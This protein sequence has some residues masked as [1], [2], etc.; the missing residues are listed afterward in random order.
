MQGPSGK[1]M[2]LWPA[3]THFMSFQLILVLFL[4]ACAT[5]ALPGGA[6]PDSTGGPAPSGLLC[7]LLPSAGAPAVTS[8]QPRFSWIV[9]S[10]EPDDVQSAYEIRVATAEAAAGPAFYDSGKVVGDQSVA[11]IYAG[12]ALQARTEYWWRVRT[13]DRRGRPSAW[14]APARLVTGSLASPRAIGD[15]GRS[16]LTQTVVAPVRMVTLG[17]GH[18]FLDFGRDGF[19]GLR[20]DLAGTVA[21]QR[22]VVHLGEAAD[23]DS[24]NRKPPGS[25][26]YLRSEVALQSGTHA[27]TAP[28]TEKD[29]RRMPPEIGPVMPF[30]YVELENVPGAFTAADARQVVAHYPFDDHAARFTSS[31]K[32]LND[33]WD[34]CH[35]SMKATSFCGVFVDGDRERLPYEADAYINQLG[36]YCTERDFALPRYTN[37]HLLDNATWPTEWSFHSVMM[38]WADYLYSGDAESLAL[39]YDELKPKTLI[40]LEGPDGLISTVHPPVPAS[41]LAAVHAPR[42]QDIVDWPGG[43]RDGYE[44]RPINTV[45]NAFHYRALREM[46]QIAIVTGHSADAARFDAAADRVK[47]AV[48]ARLFDSATGLYVDGAGAM[49]GHPGDVSSHSALHANLFP[50]AFGLVPPDRMPKVAAFV[51]S[52]GMACS[53]YAAQYLM[54]ALYAS[55]QGAYALDLMLAP[56]DRSWDH[57]AHG[58]GATITTEAWDQRYKPNQDWNHAWGAAPANVIPRLLMGVE[59]T[60]PGFRTMRIRPQPGNLQTA[61]LD[62]PTVRGTVHVDFVSHADRFALNVR[63]PANTRAEVCLPRYAG[64]EGR[65]L[66]DGKPRAGRVEGNY[67]IIDNV[68]SGLHVFTL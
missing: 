42:L 28:L 53:V 14:S 1:M 43:E 2:N 22:V 32:R 16:A 3:G 62:L 19:A 55:D 27:Y 54:E 20:L 38:S 31:D 21:G 13:H 33:V 51:R 17:P 23:G 26:R 64:R 45:V 41:V 59:P 50:V 49:A 8:P 11:V 52:R 44:M 65:V 67:V 58:I 37:E 10:N 6:A 40:D 47:A 12:P 7:D 9:N 30:R 63:L 57:M 35:Y 24:V 68:G 25:V 34:L 48:N 56:G 36:W 4:A 46:A 39:C 15:V 18:Y 60:E 29:A 66:M 5:V 61:S